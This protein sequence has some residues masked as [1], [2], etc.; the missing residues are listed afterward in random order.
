MPTL[1]ER[2]NA[3]GDDLSA[4]KRKVADFL[5][6]KAD[7]DLTPDEFEQ[8]KT[9]RTEAEAADDNLQRLRQLREWQ[10]ESDKDIERLKN[11][12]AL[13]P[14]RQTSTPGQ[15]NPTITGGRDSL[16]FRDFGEQ[17]T[18]IAHAG[19]PTGMMSIDPRLL[20]IDPNGAKKL[21]ISGSSTTIGSDGLFLVQ[22]D[23]AT[24]ILRLSHAENPILSRIR[25]IP[26]SSDSD[27]LV[28]NAIDETSR[29][30]GSRW[31]GV[32]VYRVAQGE[33]MTG[34][35]PTLRQVKWSLKKLLGAWY[36]TDETLKDAAAMEAVASEA[37]SEEI[38]YVTADEVINGD[39]AS[40]MKGIL[41][42][43]ALNSI[44][45]ETG[46][47][48]TTLVK[49]NID[50]MFSRCWGPSRMN[51]VWLINQDVE[52]ALFSLTQDV[53]TGGSAVYLPP[54]H[55]LNASPHSTLYGLPVIPCEHC[56]TLGTV[57]DI[58]LVDLSQYIM[59]EKGGVDT[60][61]SIHLRF[62]YGETVFRWVTRNDGQTPWSNV[63]TPASGSTNYLSPFCVTATRS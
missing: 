29:A 47:V 18:A 8:C 35:K 44:T 52:P 45:K 3:A 41:N 48:A 62:D 4:K 37:F 25:T 51:A 60:A 23:F 49:E 10:V 58:M 36:V 12:S 26:I 56:P 24:E 54:G 11:E 6:S 16:R 5:K 43:Q 42:S 30:T 2:I 7:E 50:K 9:W 13:G 53:G 38:A 63:L 17:L 32:Q 33:Q 21:A 39:G 31:G 14:P 28:L 22:P 40:Q 20:G 34:K 15:S 46:Q 55:T 1:E 57:G 27:S 61:S 19:T 59:I